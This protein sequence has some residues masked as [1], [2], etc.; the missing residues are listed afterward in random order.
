[1]KNYL[2]PYAEPARVLLSAI[3]GLLVVFGALTAANAA[4]VIG[5][6]LAFGVAFWKWYDAGIVDTN[7]T[8]HAKAMLACVSGVLLAFGYFDA[9]TITTFV[10]IATAVVTTV[11]TVVSTYKK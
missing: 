9:N 7:P 1:M 8:E 5:A 6:A 2:R 4:V 10:G 11:W 3:V